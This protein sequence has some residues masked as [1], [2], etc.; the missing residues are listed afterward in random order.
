SRTG[1]RW[2]PARSG[3]CPGHGCAATEPY[4]GACWMASNPSF[5]NPVMTLCAVGA[6]SAVERPS[7]ET[8]AQQAARIL[9][10]MNAYLAS[11]SLATAGQ[12]T[13]TWI[14]L[15]NDRANLAYLATGP[16]NQIAVVLR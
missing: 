12:W 3:W 8:T 5:V 7:G 14:A 4:K 13:V 1:N 9:S 6:T 2:A 16:N 10:G 15:T 11:A